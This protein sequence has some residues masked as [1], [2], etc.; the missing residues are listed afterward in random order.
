MGASQNAPQVV[1]TLAA[2]AALHT[3]GAGQVFGAQSVVTWLTQLPEPQKG[4]HR[5]LVHDAPVGHVPMPAPH[6]HRP[7]AL[8]VLVAPT[9]VW[10]CAVEV[11]SGS[12]QPGRAAQM[13]V[14]HESQPDFSAEPWTQGSCR[15]VPA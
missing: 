7:C 6:E 3:F 11:Q 8:Q 14:A 2:H 1:A 9:S 5:P 13:A 10:H 15:H 12:Q 4:T